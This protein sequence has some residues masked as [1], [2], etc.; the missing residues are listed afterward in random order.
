MPVYVLGPD[1]PDKFIAY[2]FCTPFSFYFIDDIVPRPAK[3]RK[4][5]STYGF[6]RYNP[7]PRRSYGGPSDLGKS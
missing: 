5:A 1:L 2:Y 4:S 3:V 6:A 7:P